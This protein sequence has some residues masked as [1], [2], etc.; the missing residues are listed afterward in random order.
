MAPL[1]AV[2][3]DAGPSLTV[4]FSGDN[5]AEVDTCG[6]T[7]RPSGGLARRVSA[8]KKAREENPDGPVLL[9][10]AGNALFESTEAPTSRTKERARFIARTMAKLETSAMAVGSRDLSAGAA[11]LVEAAAASELPMLSANLVDKHGKA[12]F[13]SSRLVEGKGRRI[14]FIGLSPVSDLGE[15]AKKEGVQGRP[16]VAALEAE[17]AKLQRRSDEKPSE[18]PDAI[19]V[20]AAVPYADALALLSR[21]RG[22]FDVLIQSNDRRTPASLQHA[23]GRLMAS[24][25]DR[26]RSLGLVR[27]PLQGTRPLRDAQ[28]LENDEQGLQ[29][30]E[31]QIADV[32]ARNNPADALTLRSFEARGEELRKKVA[33]ARASSARPVRLVFWTLDEAFPPEPGIQAEAKKFGPVGTR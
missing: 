20:L 10:D 11:F 19:V 23:E 28:R 15:A 25:G 24:A 29:R 6:C 27:F 21:T 16:L 26:G 9:V 5:R 33:E 2:A 12:L 7:V 1:G 32:K 8:V 18:K 4:L 17:L 3:F 14:A 31:A 22:D 13:P 30:I